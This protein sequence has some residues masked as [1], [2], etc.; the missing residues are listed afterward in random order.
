MEEYMGEGNKKY[1]IDDE[2]FICP[3]TQDYFV[4]PVLASDGHFYNRADIKKWLDDNNTSPMTNEPLKNK[5]LTTVYKFN[6]ILEKF[7]NENPNK[8]PKPTTVDIVDSILD[9][10]NTVISNRETSNEKKKEITIWNDKK[11]IEILLREL[12][13][14][15]RFKNGHTLFKNILSECSDESIIK[16][17]IKHT[18]GR[19]ICDY[20]DMVNHNFSLTKEQKID[21]VKF[22]FIHSRIDK[23]KL[24]VTIPSLCN[25][26]MKSHAFEIMKFI[27]EHNVVTHVQYSIVGENITIVN[28]IS[29]LDIP[30]EK[31]I[32]LLIVYMEKYPD[33]DINSIYNGY[34]M[35]QRYVQTNYNFIKDTTFLIKFV[36]YLIS[37]KVDV[38]ITSVEKWTALFYMCANSYISKENKYIIIKLL[39]E[40]GGANLNIKDKDN[41]T[42]LYVLCETDMGCEKEDLFLDIIKF[43]ISHGASISDL[44]KPMRNHLWKLFLDDKLM[45]MTN[46]EILSFFS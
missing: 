11:D 15:Y 37:K 14:S 9:K 13:S 12:P 46:T 31:Q 44:T 35:L 33:M 3:I 25:I 42:P 6:A 26:T 34:T 2:E 1:K 8:R 20:N 40:K 5:T 29:H 41:K 39:V 4:D 27:I 21:I 28:Y 32:E 45:R 30:V 10:I 36:E 22:F 16:M 18:D 38:N 23:Q 24:A 43:L 19:I 17:A 7:Y